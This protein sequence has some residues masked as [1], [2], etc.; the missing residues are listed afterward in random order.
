MG[1]V[2]LAVAGCGV[3]G[4]VVRFVLVSVG[5]GVGGGG[6]NRTSSMEINCIAAICVR[7]YVSC[8]MKCDALRVASGKSGRLAT[9]CK[10]DPV[11]CRSQFR[12]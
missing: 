10:E 8:E 4:R 3:I 11:M 1:T 6:G 9:S 12:G 7:V 2:V 5:V